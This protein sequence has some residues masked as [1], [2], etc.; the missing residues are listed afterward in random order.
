MG[1]IILS[2]NAE[3]GRKVEIAY[4][5]LYLIV[6]HLHI[7]DW[8]TLRLV[9][10]GFNQFAFGLPLFRDLVFRANSEDIEMFEYISRHPQWA[11]Q[12]R[13]VIYDKGYQGHIPPPQSWMTLGLDPAAYFR[14]IYLEH[15]KVTN[16]E[17]EA[18]EAHA[19]NRILVDHLGKLAAGL[20]RLP[21]VFRFQIWFG[22][23]Y[24]RDRNVNEKQSWKY[25]S[26][27]SG[28]WTEPPS[29]YPVFPF[30]VQL[31]FDTMVKSNAAITEFTTGTFKEQTNQ[32][33][34]SILQPFESFTFETPIRQGVEGMFAKFKTLKLRLN[35]QKSA[36]AKQFLPFARLLQ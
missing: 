20:Q 15:M 30:M 21:N 36:G 26:P 12:V 13:T 29:W 22:R 19:E 4:D 5:I 7:S 16:P 35:E 10:R 3:T 8:R 25:L 9:S 1:S 17:H 14:I 2:P 6:D 11:K 31:I 23:R 27:Y 28:S 32:Q 34:T 24:I 33:L 18:D